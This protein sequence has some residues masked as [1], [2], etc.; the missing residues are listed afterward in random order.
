LPG[1]ATASSA[2]LAKQLR[3]GLTK[4]NLLVSVSEEP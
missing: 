1:A 4:M 3:G 2:E